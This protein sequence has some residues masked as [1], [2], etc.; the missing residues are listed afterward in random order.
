MLWLADKPF[1]SNALFPRA[2]FSG[3]TRMDEGLPGSPRAGAAEHTAASSAAA[4]SPQ[5]GRI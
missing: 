3:R 5:R 2:S 4:I 1:L